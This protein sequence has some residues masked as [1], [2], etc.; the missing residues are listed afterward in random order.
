MLFLLSG[1][2]SVRELSETAAS[3]ESLSDTEFISS[4]AFSGLF[5]G[6]SSFCCTLQNQNRTM[7]AMIRMTAEM[8][9]RRSRF[10]LPVPDLADNSF[11]MQ[12]PSAFY[13]K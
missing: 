5:F 12:K 7:A 3:D 11:F 1:R 13:M 9:V 2:T 4:C 10:F 6:E 8:T